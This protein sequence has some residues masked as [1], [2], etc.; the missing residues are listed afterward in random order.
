LHTLRAQY[1][2]SVRAT[3][4]KDIFEALQLEYVAPERRSV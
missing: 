3:C 1:E 4:E 2:A